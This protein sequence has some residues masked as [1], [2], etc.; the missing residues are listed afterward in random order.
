MDKNVS[1]ER[2]INTILCFHSFM[3]QHIFDIIKHLLQQKFVNCWQKSIEHKD[4]NLVKKS[5]TPKIKT[6]K[7]C[8]IRTTII[9]LFFPVDKSVTKLRIINVKLRFYADYIPIRARNEIGTTQNEYDFSITTVLGVTRIFRFMQI[10][11]N[12]V[13]YCPLQF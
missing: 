3:V 10:P 12:D 13:K 2:R 9:S 8:S 6:D 1:S 5:D 7:L 4:I 11:Y